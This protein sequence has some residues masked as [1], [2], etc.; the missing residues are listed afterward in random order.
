MVQAFTLTD[1]AKRREIAV[2][3]SNMQLGTRIEIKDESRT[4]RQNRAIHGLVGQ[5]MKQRPEHR[6]I[7]MSMEAYKAIFMHGLGQEI[8]MLP[9]L[10]GTGFVPLGLSTSALNVSDFNDLMEFVLAWCAQEGLTIRHF[11]GQEPEERQQRPPVA[12]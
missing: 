7:R 3:I 1:R 10:D 8:T 6:G 2:M 9:S 4:A 5:I 12:A 11:D